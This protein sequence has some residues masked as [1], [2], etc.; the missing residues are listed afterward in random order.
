MFIWKCVYFTLLFEEYLPL[1]EN[2]GLTVSLPRNVIPLFSGLYSFWWEAGVQCYQCFLICNVFFPLLAVFKTLFFP[3]LKSEL[4]LSYLVVVF[5]VLIMLRGSWE[6][7]IFKLKFLINFEICLCIT[8]QI[9]FCPV[10]NFLSFCNYC[11]KKGCLSYNCS[12]RSESLFILLQ[13]FF[14]LFQIGKLLLLRLQKSLTLLP[15]LKTY[16]VKVLFQWLYCQ[17]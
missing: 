4:W 14:S 3:L 1:I 8:F 7:W 16:L 12:S 2:A 6:F 13:L 17:F 15:S 9:L 5:F 10:L 11:Y